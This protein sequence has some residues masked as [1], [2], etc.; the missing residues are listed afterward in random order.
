MNKTTHNKLIYQ[1]LIL[2]SL[3]FTLCAC[4]DDEPPP[5]P[6]PEPLTHPTRAHDEVRY[7]APQ[8]ND[9]AGHWSK[10]LRAITLDTQD[11]IIL[12]GSVTGDLATNG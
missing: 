5:A 8:L 1:I 2:F 3:A 9:E 4:G 6:E 10:E 7:E 11:E 12:K